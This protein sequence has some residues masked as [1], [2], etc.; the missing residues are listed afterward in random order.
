MRK[1]SQTDIIDRT[2]AKLDWRIQENERTGI[3]ARSAVS[4]GELYRRS[5]RDSAESPTESV[6]QYGFRVNRRLREESKSL[7]EAK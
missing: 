6:R 1:E 7:S 2:L 4:L 3:T 5:I